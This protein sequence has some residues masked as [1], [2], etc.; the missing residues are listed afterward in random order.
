MCRHQKSVSPCI[1]THVRDT[2]FDADTIVGMK[3]Y[4]TAVLHM[5]AKLYFCACWE[6]DVGSSDKPICPGPWCNHERYNTSSFTYWHSSCLFRFKLY[7]QWSNSQFRQDDGSVLI[8]QMEKMH[9]V[10]LNDKE[11]GRIVLWQQPPIM[12]WISLEVKLRM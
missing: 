1:T 10:C 7:F 3:N 12:Q 11:V 2:L 5:N 8:T 6:I 9:I 4:K